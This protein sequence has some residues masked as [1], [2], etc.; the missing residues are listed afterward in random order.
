EVPGMERYLRG[1][2]EV[3]AS[4]P[5]AALQAQVVAARSYALR[6]ITALGIRDHCRCHLV[7]TPAD[8]NYEGWS[9][10]A[11]A[12]QA[13]RSAVDATAGQVLVH[14]GTI[15]ETFYSS[16]HGGWSE[17]SRFVFGGEL[18]YIQPVD[19]R[20]WDLAS[21]NPYRR[22]AVAFTAAEMGAAAK[23]GVATSVELLEPRGA[24][25]RVG[26]PD[27]GYGGVRVTGTEGTVVLSGNTLRQRLGLRSTLFNVFSNVGPP[28]P[29]P[30]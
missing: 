19:D 25:G 4:W 15:A 17:S 22:W 8:Q 28:P 9:H 2:A 3:P 5:S 26:D 10:E 24:G 16:S 18:P 20:R 29:A 21:D 23:V 6:R 13:W 14:D 7:A 11:A 12:G 30:P 1:I 27:R